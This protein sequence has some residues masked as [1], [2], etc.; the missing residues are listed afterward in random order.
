MNSSQA[1]WLFWCVLGGAA[2]I[3]FILT[4]Y[5]LLLYSVKEDDLADFSFSGSRI[6]VIDLHGP[7]FEAR[8]WVDQIK[9]FGDSPSI[10]AII[11]HIDSPGGGVAA[12][13]EIYQEVLRLRDHKKKIVVSSMAS[14]GAS[15]AYYIACACDKIVANP[16]TVTGSIGVIAEWYNY[17][18]LLQWAKL[19]NVVFKSGEFKDAPSPVRDLTENERKYMQGVIDDL[20]NQFTLAVSKGRNLD[21]AV[22]K[23]LADGRIYTGLDAKSRRLIDEIGTFQDAVEITAKLAKIEGEPKLVHPVKEHRTFWDLLSGDLSSIFPIN[24]QNRG[25]QIQFS[26]LWK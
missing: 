10:K 20:Y 23:P 19:K 15:G 25:T 5:A 21:L 11:L 4:V 6:G 12:S 3:F 1:K 17:G 2:L 26:Y 16:G 14:V 9:K 22:V 24:N 7:I 18:E 8:S 13:Q